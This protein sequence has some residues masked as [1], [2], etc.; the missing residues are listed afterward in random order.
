MEVSIVTLVASMIIH[1]HYLM[2]EF[3]EIH[4]FQ[5]FFTRKLHAYM[6]D[7]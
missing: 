1:V 4:Y 7:G 3:S 6:S 2:K 5:D